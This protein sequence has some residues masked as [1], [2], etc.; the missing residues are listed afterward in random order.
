M[1]KIRVITIGLGITAFAVLVCWGWVPKSISNTKCQL[2]NNAAWIGVD[3]T[4]Q[5]TEETTIRKL[6]ESATARRIRY[7][8]PYT[9]FVKP[10]G[11]FSPSYR[12]ARQ[13]VSQFRDFNQ[14]TFLLAWLGVPLKNQRLIGI[15][16]WV[17]L[18]DSATRKKIVTFTDTLIREAGFDGVHLDV[19]TV[20]NN[21]PTFLIL[22]EEL[23]NTNRK[24]KISI[25]G[26]HWVPD[27]V[28][29]L[30]PIHDFRWTSSYYQQVAQR[31]D[32][33]V[34]MTYDSYAPIGAIYRLWVREQVRGIGWSLLQSNTELLIGISV[35]REETLSHHPN[36]EN[37]ANGLAGL[38][39]ALSDSNIKIHGVAIYA[40]WE[41]SS[42][43]QQIWN[44]W[45]NR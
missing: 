39:A 28:N 14:D 34:T 20:Q 1:H 9:T 18:N 2:T 10:D 44:K 19:E 35:S 6:A 11:S 5:P 26:S 4:S 32:Q 37:L 3:W 21:D 33:I 16:G 42:G 23:R 7:L 40:D 41:F 15:K 38:C 25:S 36:V 30:P 29:L 31:V 24:S 27:A 17:D 45:Q 22:L 13:F 43:D 12:Y 8:F